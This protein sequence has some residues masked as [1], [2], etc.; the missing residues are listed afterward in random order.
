M[1]RRL[2][3]RLRALFRAG[4]LE[5]DMEREIRFHLEM[6]I[7]ENMRRGLSWEEARRRGLRRFGGVE[8]V[9][10]ECRDIVRA[11]RL[12]ALWQDL[13][14][15]AMILRRNP[16]S[17]LV[18]VITLALA[19]GANTAIFSVI[20]GAVLR[21]LPY[22]DG[23]RLVVVHQSAPLAGVED[24]GFSV[25]EIDDYRGQNR[26]L[27]DL[28]EYHSMAFT[29]FG[30]AEPERIQTGVVSANFFDAMGV[31]PLLG[32]TFLAGDEE[33]GAEA[34]LVLSYQYWQ[35]SHRGD[36]G[37]VGKV[38]AMNDRPHTVVGVLPP[39]PQFPNENDV[40]M[41]TS[42]CPTRS[43][44]RF[45]ADRNARMMSVI[46]RLKP[47]VRVEQAQADFAN[48]AGR[49]QQD[50]PDSYPANRG[51]QATV[52]SLQDELTRE[53]R[54]TLLI[55]LGTTGLVLL[56]ACA[57]V[58][59][60]SLARL[61]QREREMA[62]RAALGASRGRLIRQLLTESTLLALIG[63]AAGIALAYLTLDLLVDFASRFTTRTAEIS[64]DTSV[65]LFTLA[66]SLITGLAFGL[67]P[68]LSSRQDLVTSLKEGASQSVA[69]GGR[70]RLRS[71]L[72]V[73]QIAVSFILLIAAGLMLRSL[74]RLQQVNP[75][76]NPEKV[77][78]MRVSPNW[79]KYTTSGQYK[80]FAM[81]LLD[82]VEGR[83][84]VLSAS[85]A[86][87]YPLNP[88]GIANG[89]FT[90]S[91]RIEGR[92]LKE[93]ELTPLADFRVVSPDYLETVRVPI[94]EGRFFSEADHEEAPLVAAVN[95]SLARHRWGDESPIGRR[96]SFDSGRS[97]VTIVGVVGDVKQYGL[98]RAPADE[99]YRPIAQLGGAP[100]LLARTAAE[101][102]SVARQI[103]EAVYEVDPET[104]IDHVHT[105]EEV[106]SES[107]ASPR[108]TTVL[109]SLFAVL[110]LII[111]TAGIA[112]V[113]ALSVSRRTHE[114]G[115]R[116]ALGATKRGVLGMVLRQGMALVLI[117]LALG[118]AGAFMLTRLMST[119]L[120]GVEPTDPLTYL[121]VSL[122]LAGAAAAACLMPARRVTTINPI[123]ALRTE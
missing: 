8:Q 17:T 111:T 96:V 2:L 12:E 92:L 13:R 91:F 70:Q 119:L 3:H 65:L 31:R 83:P 38:F 19:I 118:S 43:S 54:P 87:N 33:E 117:G 28:V 23:D 58:G 44:E 32:R 11:R 67:M 4:E 66:V 40:Y 98:D 29:L 90:R 99:I 107:L 94:V 102:L 116:L 42:A 75:G 86:N 115:I 49:L 81:R 25:K 79:S 89:P 5:R 120:F 110:A 71:V 41:P 53:A 106:R 7:Q 27:H 122:T 6:E 62:V 30:G 36:P 74:I 114:L 76:F 73:T 93:E 104:A 52:A 20:Y 64:L 24:L 15:G 59:N 35:R 109:L 80:S 72:V 108:L 37:V 55:L 9:K 63:G 95:Q 45:K 14:Y 22:Q 85:M 47:E 69:G 56:I 97:W 39:I 50:Y 57:N 26:S 112:G 10:E 21:P 88:L 1:I 16:G 103:R 68:A 113:M 60:L 48:I 34:V 61:M 84:G 82:K 121:A 78:V 18:A 123:Q 77:L 105:L 46:G 100:F 101:P 51:H